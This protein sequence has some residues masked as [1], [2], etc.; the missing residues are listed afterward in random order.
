VTKILPKHAQ[1]LEGKSREVLSIDAE[2][3]RQTVVENTLRARLTAVAEDER[4][5]RST[6][7]DLRNEVRK[8]T[9]QSDSNVFESKLL[10]AHIQERTRELQQLD[11]LRADAERTLAK[12]DERQQNSADIDAGKEDILKEIKSR[13]AELLNLESEITSRKKQLE[14][15]DVTSRD[16]LLRLQDDV[17]QRKAAANWEAERDTLKDRLA[18][19]KKEIQVVK[20][21]Q[22]LAESDRLSAL[23]ALSS[24]KTDLLSAADEERYGSVL[25][26]WRSVSGDEP[27]SGKLKAIWAEIEE[28]R[29]RL[30]ELIEA[31]RQKETQLKKLKKTLEAN[32]DKFHVFEERLMKDSAASKEEFERDE[33]RLIER[34]KKVKIRLAQWRIDHP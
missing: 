27:A 3:D 7:F 14:D 5:L 9:F 16:Q 25:R 24:A 30:L 20:S 26:A 12:L 1:K 8:A 21:E 23:S 34:I 31:N 4:N 10:H 15:F 22:R 13:T 17:Q 19:L 33:S 6:I 11:L 32:V 28:P 29:L 18:R 2:I